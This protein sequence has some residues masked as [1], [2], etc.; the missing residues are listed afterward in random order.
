MSAILLVS[1]F[2]ILGITDNLILL[3]EKEAGLWQF[4][5]FRSLFAIPFLL[6]LSKL[7]GL[8]IKPLRLKFVFLRTFLV[9]V[10]LLLYFGS[11]PIMPLAIAASGL[12]TSPIFVLFFSSLLFG[13]KIKFRQFII[14]SLGA[15]GVW[16]ILQ[17]DTPG[18]SI[19]WLVPVLAGAIYALNNISTRQFCS[20]EPPLCLVIFFYISL[21]F[22]G[23][24]GATFF[25]YTAISPELRS[26]SP[27]VFSGWKTASIYF[28]IYAFIYAIASVIAVAMVTR[29]YQI[30]Q[31][32]NITIFD[33]SFVIFLSLGGWIF[34]NQELSNFHL[35][36]ILIIILAGSLA[37]T[38]KQF[39][40]Q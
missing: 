28:F 8:S 4:H 23:L 34:W 2:A 11:L 1:G 33:Y 37:S 27:F 24:I 20:E 35:L 7:L 26:I 3:I 22:C 13:Q 16:F 30:S 40:N 18:F 10:A 39:S 9:T 38:Q 32:S 21:G 17:P 14:V 15:A 36:G 5:F 6:I 29:A 19:L 25:S 31:T 12:F